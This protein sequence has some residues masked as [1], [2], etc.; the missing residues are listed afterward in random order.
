LA[1]T[2]MQAAWINPAVRGSACMQVLAK[3]AVP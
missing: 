3:Q 2:C 1:S